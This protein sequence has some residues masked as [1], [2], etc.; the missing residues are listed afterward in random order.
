MGSSK[1]PRVDLEQTSSSLSKKF[2]TTL[3]PM[4]LS[5]PSLDRLL[6]EQLKG[7]YKVSE[8]TDNTMAG[9]AGVLADSRGAA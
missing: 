6:R 1:R 7:D 5:D 3:P 8:P 2:E 4:A 9:A